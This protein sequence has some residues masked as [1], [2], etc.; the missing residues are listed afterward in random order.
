[1]G[2]GKGSKGKG[3]KKGKKGKSKRGAVTESRPWVSAVARTGACIIVQLVGSW[4]GLGLSTFALLAVLI[5]FSRLRERRL[6]LKHQV[7]RHHRKMMNRTGFAALFSGA[8]KELAPPWITYTETEKSNMLNATVEHL[9]PSVKG[10]TEEV[11]RAREGGREKKQWERKREKGGSRREEE[12]GESVRRCERERA[13][14]CLSFSLSLSLSLSLS[15]HTD[16][17]TL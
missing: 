9:W 4:I 12:E 3:S 16:T 17:L 8:L 11:R 5:A 2:K 13:R 1:M 6:A 10:A 14:D 7:V 15:V